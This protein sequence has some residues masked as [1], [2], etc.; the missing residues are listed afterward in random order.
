MELNEKHKLFC[1]ELYKQKGNQRKAYK[2]IYGDNLSDEV[3]DVN[4]S[5]LLSNAK[6][7]KYF[8]S[9]S[10]KIEKKALIT[11]EE[12]IEGIK[13]DIKDAKK[14]KQMSAVLKGRE[15]LGK[16]LKMFTEKFEHTGKDGEPIEQTIIFDF[17]NNDKN[18]LPS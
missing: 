13:E 18:S 8:T 14:Y 7:F 9:L 12:V 16:Y 6:I 1:Q 10:E 3:A 5:R 17:N 11:I 4:A 2:A 15:L